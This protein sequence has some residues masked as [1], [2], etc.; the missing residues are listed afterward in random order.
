LAA[1]AEA[2]ALIESGVHVG[3]IMLDVQSAA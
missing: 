2:H 3:K 1:A